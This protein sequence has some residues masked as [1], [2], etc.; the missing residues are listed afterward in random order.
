MST[1]STQQRCPWCGTDPIYTDY[2]DTEWGV[3]IH[4]DQT[5]F[6]LLLLEGAQA[7]LSWI[8]ILRKRDNYRKAFDNFDPQKMARYTQKRHEKLLNNEGIIRNKL[9][10]AAFTKN[11]IAY[12]N[13]INSGTRFSDF[14]WQFTEHKTITNQWQEMSEVPAF[15]DEST[16]MSKALKKA[17]FTFVG[18]TICYAFMQSAGMVNDHLVT[19]FRY[20]ELKKTT[21]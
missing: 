17:G 1:L 11:A 2:H 16:A 4:D 14:L 20:D 10:V 18:P 8:T 21:S 6:E 15:T 9:K 5:L 7:G 19:C 12:L 3:P 13:I